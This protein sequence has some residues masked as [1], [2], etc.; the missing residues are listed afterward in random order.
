VLNVV[1]PQRAGNI[2][3]QSG[4]KLVNNRWVDID[5]LTMESTSTPGIHVLGDAIFPAPTMPKSG[6]MAN[7]HAKV[8][9]AAIVNL[10]SGQPPSDAPVVMNTCY[11][12]VDNV[13]VVH[14][15][16]VHAYD[17]ATKPQPVK[18]AGGL[19]TGAV[20]SR[21]ASTRWPG[22]RTSGPTC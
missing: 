20:R 14:V 16:S 10:M 22:R 8:A 6:H 18:G 9:A 5:W 11:S 13:N 12:F 2:A 1:P 4:L 3:A 15:A 17:A 19:S 21:K 7:Q